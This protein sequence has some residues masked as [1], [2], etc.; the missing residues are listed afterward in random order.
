MMNDDSAKTWIL[1]CQALEAEVNALREDKEQLWQRCRERD[2][3]IERWKVQSDAH[4]LNWAGVRAERD[5]AK[6]EAERFR[7]ALEQIAAPALGPSAWTNKQ[8]RN[9]AR[10]ALG[11]K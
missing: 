1:R 4:R 7:A 5:E 11:Q 10:Q 3:E 6:V 8:R 2:D 9:I